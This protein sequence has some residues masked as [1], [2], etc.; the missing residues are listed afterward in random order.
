M[1]DSIYH[2]VL[3]LL[4][5]RFFGVETSRFRHL[6][7]NV[8]VT[9]SVNHYLFIDFILRRIITLRRDVRL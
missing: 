6:L 8:N 7:R 9:K 3:Q 1:L 4:K 5:S 2:I